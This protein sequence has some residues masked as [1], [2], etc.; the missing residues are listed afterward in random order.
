[1]PKI[2]CCQ[3]NSLHNLF[4]PSFAHM[5]LLI[6]MEIPSSVGNPTITKF[7]EQMDYEIFTLHIQHLLSISVINLVIQEFIANALCQ[8]DQMKAPSF[9]LHTKSRTFPHFNLSLCGMMPY[10]L[11]TIVLGGGFQ[12]CNMFL[13]MAN[14][15]L[16]KSSH[17]FH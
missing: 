13:P 5:V 9:V 6:P 10:H 2:S 16:R 1:M 8:I 17:E 12:A 4:C 11:V 15:F 3:S 7:Y 14:V